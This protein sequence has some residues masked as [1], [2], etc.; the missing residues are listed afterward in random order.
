MKFHPSDPGISP[1]TLPAAQMKHSSDT[2]DR[3]FPEERPQE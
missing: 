1:A 3:A 2:S